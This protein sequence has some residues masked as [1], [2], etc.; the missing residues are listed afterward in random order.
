LLSVKNVFS[1][2]VNANEAVVED[3]VN[4]TTAV[5]WRTLGCVTPVKDQGACGSC[6]AFSATETVESAHC[7]ANN[8]DLQV[9]SPQ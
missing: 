4:N 8:H 2:D 5:D 9:L 7:V 3:V 1:E 6:W